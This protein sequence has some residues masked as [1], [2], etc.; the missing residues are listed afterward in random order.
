MA[1]QAQTAFERWWWARGFAPAPRREVATGDEVLYRVLSRSSAAESASPGGYFTRTPV[2]SVTDAESR[3][4]I[5]DYDNP[6]R[7]SGRFSVETGTVMWVGPVRH[8]HGDL[9][10]QGAEQ[11]YIENPVG[12][13]AMTDH[14][15][16]KQDAFVVP[17]AGRKRPA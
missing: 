3:L 5:V 4:N 8:Q 14:L 7:L 17:A 9:A 16:I 13:A 12:A 1:Q 10:R 15:P 11:I 2:A 6:I